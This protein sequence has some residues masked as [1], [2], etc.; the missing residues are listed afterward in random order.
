MRKITMCFGT[1][2]LEEL[3][4][5]WTQLYFKTGGLSPSNNQHHHHM[6]QAECACELLKWYSLVWVLLFELKT[7]N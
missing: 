7:V 3:Q 6:Q 1:L 2:A 5:S 4:C